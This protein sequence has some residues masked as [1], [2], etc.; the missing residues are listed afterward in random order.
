MISTIGMFD[1]HLQYK[2]IRKKIMETSK[3][4]V[5]ADNP[6]LNNCVENSSTDSVDMP[7]DE[8]KTSIEESRSGKSAGTID[9]E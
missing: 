5:P 6:V 2:Q 8:T 1:I 3:V 9:N 4:I 7:N